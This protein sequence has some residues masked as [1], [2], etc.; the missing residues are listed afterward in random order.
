MA[1]ERTLPVR[2]SV[3][4]AA[5]SLASVVFALKSWPGP[6]I[7]RWLF[8][9]QDLEAGI[10]MVAIWLL[11]LC[12][13]PR[14]AFSC[15]PPN[16]AIV[17]AIAALFALGL[18]AG[19]HALMLDYALTRDELMAVFDQAN[20]A[21]G[22]LSAPL[23]ARW[24]GYGLSLVPA[25][26]L[27]VPGQALLSSSYGP[28][29]AALRAGFGFM[30]DPALLNPLLA[31]V[32]LVAL[33]RIVRRLFADSAGAQWL[34][35]IGYVLSAQIAVNAMTS[36]A[37]TAHLAF[38]LVWLA[39]FLRDRW[40][41][42]ALAMVVGAL[43]IGL[44]QV[45]FHPL[46][47]GPFILW[48]LADRRWRLAAAYAAAY[49]AALA[50][51][52]SWPHI[53]SLTGGVPIK[54]GIITGSGGFIATRVL[55]LLLNYDSADLLLMFYN[56]VRAVMWNAVFLVPFALLAIPAIRRR[57]G[58]AIPLA[59]GVVLTIL[60]MAALLPYQGHGWGYRYIHGVLGNCLLLAG[61]G[62]R[63]LARRDKIFAPVFAA[64]LA[65]ATLPITAWLLT[66]THYFIAPY[67]L[68]SE[69][70][71]RQDADFA[72]VESDGEDFAVDQVRN[73]PDLTNRPLLFLSAR[74][75]PAQVIEL[76]ERGSIVLIRRS[77]MRSGDQFLRL[78]PARSASYD[79]QVLPLAGRRCVRPF[80][81]F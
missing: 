9:H 50:L 12:L 75:A 70:I 57:E 41:S 29:N 56:L 31:A 38:N 40:W 63:E 46:F 16:L 34:V 1:L 30:A 81:A 14:R 13:K 8:L 32:G 36:Y 10:A 21:G 22:R 44:H 79:R 65:V 47:A 77:L 60:A 37:M 2:L 3:L 64:V 15:Q 61:Y 55:P 48:L 67:A 6:V 73:R 68:L 53:V 7:T 49:L 42:H 74:L 23:P 20:F 4:G 59:A 33:H 39:L 5:A 43:A 54:S 11:A 19:T 51:W 28:V 58:L 18:W 80:T 71:A 76:C 25:F 62:Y 69:G 52:M 17:L 27:D 78:E 45:I 26:L 35:L 24:A 72:I 66:T